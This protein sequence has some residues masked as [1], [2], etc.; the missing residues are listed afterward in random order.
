MAYPNLH[1]KAAALLHSLA[2]NPPFI[3]GNKRI[4]WLATGAFY[5]ANGQLLDAPDDPAYALVIGVA[6]GELDVPDIAETL[7][8]WVVPR[9]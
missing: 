9:S 2:R 6:T 3:D 8:Q 4:A 7:A 1:L 5:F